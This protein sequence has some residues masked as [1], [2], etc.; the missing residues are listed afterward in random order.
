MEHI[1]PATHARLARR[2]GFLRIFLLLLITLAGVL[3]ALSTGSIETGLPG[4][5]DVMTGESNETTR[6]V[7]ME[8]RLPRAIH[9]FITGGLLAMAGALMQVLLRNPLA[10]PYVLGISGG[11]AVFALLA[12]V[13]GAAGM[14]VSVA[15]FAGAMLAMLL[16]FSLAHGRGSWTATRLL[17]TGIVLASGWGAIISFILSISPQGQLRSLLFWLIGDLSF[18]ESYLPGSITLVV[19]LV[20]GLLFA[21]NLNLLALGAEQATTFGLELR[22]FRWQIY[23][24]ASLLTATAVVQVGN[25]GF[26]GLVV[27]HLLRLV[28]IHDYRFLLPS[29]VFAGGSL[30]L[31]ADTLARSIVPDTVLPV[32]ILT[33]AIGVPLF[34]YLLY[35]GRKNL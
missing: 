1:N 3:F 30:L 20:I 11:A 25:V 32:G 26:V 28:G 9:A 17:L 6:R 7:V 14:S 34:I 35:R 8:L 27:P 29:A 23:L 5:L 31:F 4:L 19:G 10:D 16:V 18:A 21:R 33:A 24:L 15:A 12:L 13:F 22:S 2:T